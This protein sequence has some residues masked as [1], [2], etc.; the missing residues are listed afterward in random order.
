[1]KGAFVLVPPNLAAPD[2]RAYQR[3]VGDA[4]AGA[5]ARARPEHVMLLSSVGANL[6][7]GTGPIVALN[8]LEQ[9][10]RD[11]GVKT[12]AMRPGFFQ[13]NLA[14]M[15]GAARDQGVYPCFFPPKMKIS[16]IATK[17]IGAEG[18]RVLQ[19][20]PERSEIVDLVGPSYDGAQTAEIFGRLVGKPVQLVAVP[21]EAQV[22]A[23]TQAGF[24]RGIAELYAEMYAAF[25][26][27]RLQPAGDR[28]VD[29]K[30]TLEET[31]RA[32]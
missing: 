8:A 20:P 24:P 7:S 2:F 31:L 4:I 23:M 9:K 12:T 29:T 5:A 17:D 16:M 3:K 18:A 21:A 1:V 25:A 14:F 13:E 32:S 10:L 19:S 22:G 6:P 15:L 27:D 28:R 30:T 26:A 11:S